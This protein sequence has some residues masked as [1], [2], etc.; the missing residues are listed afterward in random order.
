MVIC[1]QCSGV[2]VGGVS[3]APLHCHGN[4][5]TIEKATSRGTTIVLLCSSV[6]KLGKTLQGQLSSSLTAVI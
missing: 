4:Q 6:G 3:K 5:K 1:Y 2:G